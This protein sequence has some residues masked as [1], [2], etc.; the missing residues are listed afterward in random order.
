MSGLKGPSDG[1]PRYSACSSVNLVSFIPR[2]FKCAAATSSSNCKHD[3]DELMTT[4]MMDN[5]FNL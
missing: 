5:R 4:F 1:I 3:L 2:W